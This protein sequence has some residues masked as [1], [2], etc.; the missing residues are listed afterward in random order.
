MWWSVCGATQVFL[1]LVL[2]VAVP[3]IAVLK[4]QPEL[5]SSPACQAIYESVFKADVENELF[6]VIVV[7][8]Q[9]V[10]S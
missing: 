1:G 4:T 3:V 10:Y 5:C 8:V 9:P 2:T 7:L 6:W